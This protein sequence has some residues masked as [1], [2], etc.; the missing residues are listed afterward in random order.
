MTET[1]RE[2][3]FDRAVGFFKLIEKLPDRM[4]DQEVEGLYKL[5]AP[6]SRAG[7]QAF[8][9]P[10]VRHGSLVF[11]KNLAGWIRNA[12]TAEQQGKKVILVPFNFPPEILIAFD[13]ACPLT[14]ELLTTLGVV[15]LEGQGERYWDL[16]MG[17]GLP[18][19]ICSSSSIELG[20]MLSGEDFNPQ[21]IISAAPGGCDANSK[22]HEFVS[23]Y[24]GIPQ[25]VIDKPVDDTP[26]GH[27]Q[28][29]IYFKRLITQLEQF[30]DEKMTEDKL[31]R[32]AE[33][34]NRCTELYYELWD[35]RKAKPCPV[36]NLYSLLLYGTR[37][38]MWGTDEG[39]NTLET[40]VSESKKRLAAKAYPAKEEIAR[41][42]WGYTSIYYDFTNLFHWMENQ[43]YTHLGDVLDLFF[44]QPIDT[45]DT[46]TMIRGMAEESWNMPMTKQMG[47]SSMS[48]MWVEDILSASKQVDAQCVI[49]CG[50]HAC[51]QT[52]SVVSILREELMKRAG[53]PLLILQADSWNRQM[54][55]IS[56]IQQEIDEFIKNVVV[57]KQKPRRKLRGK[58]STSI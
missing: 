11:L 22:I 39:I 15:A 38:A 56:V 27:E 58:K 25:F 16:A 47:S 13:N 44:P 54:T 45:T 6:D 41:C 8:F 28:Y 36:P 9:T 34:A 55:P 14:S 50:H 48:M 42:L 46:E 32:V 29:L 12:K 17:L 35:L 24:L 3:L 40:M 26:K 30:L 23:H 49:F 2:G 19:H 4:S 33:K 43:G 7:L 18:D 5:L 53:I 51:K 20:S 37:F 1:V 31:R 10:H 57:K 21:G 52:W